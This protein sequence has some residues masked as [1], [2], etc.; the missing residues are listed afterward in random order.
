[1]AGCTTRIE[2]TNIYFPTTGYGLPQS[3]LWIHIAINLCETQADILHRL[4]KTDLGLSNIPDLQHHWWTLLLN[5][6]L[7]IAPIG[8]PV[9]VLDI[10]TG[11]GIW[12]IQFARQHP[13]SNVIGTDLSFIQPNS[14]CPP[15]CT[16]EREDS[17]EEWVFDKNFDYIHWRLMCTCFDDF[18]SMFL[19]VFDHLKPG[20]WAEFHESVFELI[21]VDEDAAGVL[22]GSAFE[23]SFRYC[24][25]AGQKMGRD[26]NAAK[27]FKR[28]LIE[29]GFVDVV[30]KQFLSPVNGWP[31]DPKDQH[32]GNW[33]CLKLP[34]FSSSIPKFLESGSM[35]VE[36]IPAFQE[37]MRFD[38]TRAEMRV[39]HP[40][41]VVYAR[42]PMDVYHS[43]P[44]SAS[45]KAEMRNSVDGVP[46]LPH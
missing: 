28:W 16:F 29:A 14:N 20:G 18:K 7:Y 24:L 36:D 31:V 46:W 45:T 1:M 42:K 33:Y 37:R 19:R 23:Q 9:D 22:H 15:N 8:H 13:K 4:N 41:C 21:P 26:F 5:E 11:T 2:R 34:R 3:L 6:R 44:S 10:G 39:Y 32:I 27:K 25:E 12:A 40:L 17:T 43:G 35:P 30:E 38:I